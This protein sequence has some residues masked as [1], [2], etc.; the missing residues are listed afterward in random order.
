MEM[1]IN[2]TPDGTREYPLHCH[3][4]Y[5]V[6]LYLEGEG[7]LRTENRNCPFEPG[8]II[9]VPPG[10]IH[11]SISRDGFSNISISGDFENK[12]HFSDPVCWKD[13]A[14]TEGKVLAQLLFE[15]RY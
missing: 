1:Q 11:G 2:K 13:N 6:M 4:A 3:Q 10:V 8:T 7:Y 14:R 5:E 9:I 15:N 12:F